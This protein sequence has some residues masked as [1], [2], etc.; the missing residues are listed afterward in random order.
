V[1]LDFTG[2]MQL[3]IYCSIIHFNGC[4]YSFFCRGV[5]VMKMKFA[6]NL[7]INEVV[8]NLLIYLMLNFHSCRP[9]DLRVLVV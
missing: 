2:Y 7:G 4:L 5:F 6:M 9:F 3:D 8:D 1:C